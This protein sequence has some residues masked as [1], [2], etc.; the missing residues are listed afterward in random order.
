MSEMASPCEEDIRAAA[1]EAAVPSASGGNQATAPAPPPAGP[2]RLSFAKALQQGVAANPQPRAVNGGPTTAAA[3]RARS[4]A[5]SSA[6][7]SGSRPS[8]GAAAG[9]AKIA[10][11]SPWP[12]AAAAA[13]SGSQPA[14]AALPQSLPCTPP[15]EVTESTPEAG[16]QATPGDD[17]TVK[18]QCD[19]RNLMPTS[20]ASAEGN[21]R[22]RK[23]FR[24]SDFLPVL[25]DDWS[26]PSL[27]STSL[28]STSFS[29]S[30]WK[31]PMASPCEEDIRAPAAS[32]A[33]AEA[34][35]S[36]DATLVADGSEASQS[37]DSVSVESAP[38]SS[39]TLT[40]E[41]ATTDRSLSDGR[42][43]RA[44]EPD[45]PEALVRR[46]EDRIN[47]RTRDLDDH[48]RNMHIQ[49]SLTQRT[50]MGE[51]QT[52]L[53]EVFDEVLALRTIIDEMR[54]PI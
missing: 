1:A 6:Q 7:P 11:S 33:A 15:G 41:K 36:L 30:T 46:L 20:W 42:L 38:S 21:A 32:A 39:A 8:Y 28:E 48:L 53:Q 50:F 10:A 25:E 45:L 44:A 17:V 18:G 4:S 31:S 35:E 14:A 13:V 19:G 51:M 22:R 16:D 12:A 37:D 23:Q 2:S 24:L 5:Q 52:M 54:Q 3:P 40:P 47:D 49:L 43:V 26:L 9:S 27:E 34:D 29:L